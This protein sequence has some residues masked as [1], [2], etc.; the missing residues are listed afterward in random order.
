MGSEWGQSHWQRREAKVAKASRVQARQ[1][2][3][4][5]D[6]EN[7]IGVAVALLQELAVLVRA[8]V[9]RIDRLDAKQ[10]KAE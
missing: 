8:L 1:A 4:L 7:E 9:E 2:E 3:S 6:M 5:A 10:R